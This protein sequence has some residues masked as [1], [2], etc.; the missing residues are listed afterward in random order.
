MPDE[1]EISTVPTTNNPK[2]SA[3]GNPAAVLTPSYD[4]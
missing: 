4:Y 2:Y 3:K 1:D